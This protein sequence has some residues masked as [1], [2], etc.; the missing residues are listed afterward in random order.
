MRPDFAP[1]PVL[2]PPAPAPAYRSSGSV[3]LRPLWL[4]YAC[5]AAP[6]IRLSS[7]GRRDRVPPLSHRIARC[8]GSPHPRG[9][10]TEI[11]STG[12]SKPGPYCR[13]E[14]HTSELQSLRHLVCRLL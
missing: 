1:L 7:V 2:P 8:P 5:P 6:S 3:L 13:S 11:A 4:Q 10:K 14:E 9:P 12:K